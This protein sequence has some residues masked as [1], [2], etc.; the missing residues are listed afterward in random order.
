MEK[1]AQ[2]K[3]GLAKASIDEPIDAY[4]RGEYI[5]LMGG[6]MVVALQTGLTRWP[7]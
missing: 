5:R 3:S 1:M 4:L 6:L 2:M 7:R